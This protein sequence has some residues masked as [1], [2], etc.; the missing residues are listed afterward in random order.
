M[1]STSTL[2]LVAVLAYGGAVMSLPMQNSYD[3]VERNYEDLDARMYDMDLEDYE[4][5]ELSGDIPAAT[6][7]EATATSTDTKKHH[8]HHGKGHHHHGNHHKHHHKGKHAGSADASPSAEPASAPD[9]QANLAARDGRHANGGGRRHHHGGR[10]GKGGR[11]G[12]RHGQEAGAGAA[13]ADPSTGAAQDPSAAAAP[14]PEV[15]ARGL[16]NKKDGDAT[17]KPPGTTSNELAADVTPSVTTPTG[18]PTADATDSKKHGTHH[19]KHG[20]QGKPGK[21]GK[22]HRKHHKHT[23]GGATASA[24]ETHAAPAAT[25]TDIE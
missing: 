14:A 7:T 8:S 12:H 25:S 20:R 18:A 16:F 2:A 22:K 1:P 11:H 4:A 23:E 24:T 17:A 19:R 9:A 6:S 13:A 15:A 21:H 10:R 5:R 3:L